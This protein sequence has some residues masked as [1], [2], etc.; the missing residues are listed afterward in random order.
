MAEAA[1]IH[2]LAPRDISLKAA[3][4]FFSVSAGIP[5]DL[6]V[7]AVVAHLVNDRPLRWEPRAVKKRYKLKFP[8]LTVSR[9]EAKRSPS[10]SSKA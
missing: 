10:A 3:M 9:Q 8:D 5:C 1:F 6:F 2:N 7:K 4:Q